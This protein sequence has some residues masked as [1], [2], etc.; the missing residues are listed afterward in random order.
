MP[1]M[2]KIFA[3]ESCTPNRRI[4]SYTYIFMECVCVC[5][6]QNTG[7]KWQ[8]MAKMAKVEKNDRKLHAESG[9]KWQ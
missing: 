8:K 9:R 1:D 4:L 3:Y 2:A 6:P 5:P 7:K